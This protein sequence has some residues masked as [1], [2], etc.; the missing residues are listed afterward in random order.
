MT[1][2]FSDGLS[3]AATWAPAASL[4]ERVLSATNRPAGGHAP[5]TTMRGAAERRSLRTLQRP[6]EGARREPL[7]DRRGSIRSARRRVDSC[8]HGWSDRNDRQL[9]IRRKGMTVETTETIGRGCDNDAHAVDIHNHIFNALFLPVRAVFAMF[10]RHYKIIPEEIGRAAGRLIEF[11]T[12]VR[13]ALGGASVEET[14]AILLS[15]AASNDDLFTRLAQE[16]PAEAAHDPTVRAGLRRLG[17]PTG[18]MALADPAQVDAT[19]AAFESL[20]RRMAK[21][22]PDS[23]FGEDERSHGVGSVSAITGWLRWIWLLTEPEAK[24]ALQ[25]CSTNRQIGLFVTHMMDMER[26]YRGGRCFYKV[27][28]DQF[29]KMRRVISQTNGRMLTFVAFDPSR[30]KGLEIVKNAVALG[31][32]GVKFY[33]PNGYRASG[34]ENAKIEKAVD[35][36]FG[37]CSDNGI[38]VFTHCN[39]QGFEAEI[40]KSGC[41]SDP[42]YWA[43]ALDKHKKLRLCFGHGGGDEWWLDIAVERCDGNPFAPGVLEL[44]ANSESVFCEFGYFN[45]LRK[46]AAADHFRKKLIEVAKDKKLRTRIAYGTDWHMPQMVV[47]SSVDYFNIFDEMFKDKDLKDWRNDFFARNAARFLN[48]DAYIERA[49]HLLTKQTIEHLGNFVVADGA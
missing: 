39:L 43:R 9:Q 32:A 26:W 24:I 34:N 19:R 22:V 36:F 45:E 47:Q 1:L 7:A 46:P 3:S 18:A 10:C 40:D 13:S 17:T 6:H 27:W 35:A 31:A 37:Y 33:P 28:P 20:L 14:Q 15:G 5:M 48:L 11:I 2:S 38:P 42:K 44:C 25:L 12:I 30:D 8:A 16:A 23:I 29:A 21:T 4:L 49:K 41:N